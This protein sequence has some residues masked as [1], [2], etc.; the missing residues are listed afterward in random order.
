MLRWIVVSCVVW[1]N[2]SLAAG[3]V[4]EG[5]SVAPVVGY[6]PTYQFVFGAA[7]FYEEEDFSLGVDFNLNFKRVYQAH[8]NVTR[9]WA[10]DWKFKIHSDVTKG[11]DPYYGEGGD[12]SP[13][14]FVRLWGTRSHSSGEII[15]K[16]NDLVSLGAFLGLRFRREEPG[17]GET[18][19]RYFPD[20]T[21]GVVGLSAEVNTLMP[22]NNP[23]EGFSFRTELSF[24]PKQMST[25]PFASTFG[26]VESTFVVYKEIL[27]EVIPEV[28]A[29][30]RLMGGYSVGHPSYLYRFHLGGANQLTGY[31][32]NRFRGD[33]YYLQ[34]TELRFPIWKLFSGAALLGFGDA[35]DNSFTNAKM[36]YGIGLRIG[37][38]PDWVS[39]IRIDFAIGRDQ[40]GIFANFGEKF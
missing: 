8:V 19:V 16:A 12:T 33:K 18:L 7:Y 14:D 26:Q 21:T 25:R 11:F 32:E 6:E 37:L 20:E 9:R 13:G 23:R 4:G 17:T 36:A 29:A 39:K 30:F 38:P 27:E 15:Y 3:A 22:V 31:L 5:H 35:T 24:G 28:V 40:Q 2:L 1:A 34:Q 10:E